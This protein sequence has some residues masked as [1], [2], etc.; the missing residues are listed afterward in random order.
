M[1]VISHVDWKSRFREG[2]NQSFEFPE[3]TFILLDFV[4]NRGGA[5]KFLGTFSRRAFLVDKG[6]YFFENANNLNFKLF[7]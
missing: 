3:K 1:V 2:G 4:Q 7:F 5:A 6:V